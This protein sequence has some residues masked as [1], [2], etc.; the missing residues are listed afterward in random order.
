MSVRQV[1]VNHLTNL[2]ILQDNL[3]RIADTDRELVCVGDR[4]FRP[5]R[6]IFSEII[7][8]LQDCA[9]VVVVMSPSYCKSDYCKLEMEQSRV[10]RKPIIIIVKEEVDERE[11]NAVTKEIFRH[12]TRIGFNMEEGQVSLQRD[13]EEVCL[14]IIQLL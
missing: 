5:G 9:V 1:W 3:Q 10:M 11:M 6:S 13:W 14:S 2:C 4:Y 12:F 8:C 7:T